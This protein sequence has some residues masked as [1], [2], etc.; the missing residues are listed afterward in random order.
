MS[1]PRSLARGA[2]PRIDLLAAPGEEAVPLHLRLYRQIRGHILSGALG[3]AARL[4]SARML[5]RD[6]AVSRNTV[7]AAFAQLVD[8]GFVE[9]RVGAGT[10]VVESLGD[11]APFARPKSSQG[12]RATAAIA[13]TAPQPLRLGERGRA[14]AELGQAEIDSDTGTGTW[15][16]NAPEFPWRD[17][18][19]LQSRQARRSGSELL[20]AFPQ[21]GLTE[22]RSQI[23]KYA[24]LARGVRCE[25][26][27]VLVVNSTQQAID[28][29]ARLLLDPRQPALIENPCYPSAY[30]ALIAA[31]ADVRGI[32]VDDEGAVVEALP[33]KSEAG[34]FYV[35]PSHQFPLGMTM[36][37]PR[38]LALL[39][40]A[41][42][43]GTW[44][45]EDDYDSEFRHDGRPIAALQALDRADRVIY[46]GTFNKVLFPGLRL[47]YL[48]VP[49]NLVDAFAAAR[50]IVDGYT[51]PLAQVVLAEFMASGQF[52]RYLRQAKRHF[53]DCRNA[54]VESIAETWGD[55]VRLGPSSTGLHIVAHLP[56]RTD[57]RALAAKVHGTPSV[58]P[59]SRYYL[60]REKKKGLMIHYGTA[61]PEEIRAAI[62]RLRPPF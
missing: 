55:A 46:V 60:G 34:L 33:E 43:T 32:P 48:I 20:A 4:P 19:R 15:A 38:R 56:G 17:W 1:G 35:T 10:V 49:E 42:R 30:A 5:A 59:L 6:L 16:T 8:E 36:S 41:E 2:S 25:A 28:L 44:I 50:R 54:V 53:A 21:A 58:A 47:A 13:R 7:E 23:A 14:M 3:P 40:W 37:L 22:L 52:A 9:R 51:A 26:G 18:N 24:S 45:L 61:G 31:G 29:A 39:H 57:D 62:R 11:A 27:Q 12:P